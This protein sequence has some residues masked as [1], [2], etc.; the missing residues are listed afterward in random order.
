MSSLETLLGTLES[1]QNVRLTNAKEYYGEQHQAL[2]LI[3]VETELCHAVIA[4]QGAHVIEFTPKQQSPLLWV[5]PKVEYKSGKAIRGGV[6][7]C[8]PWFGENQLDKTQPSHGFVR[9]RDWQLTNASAQA[10]GEVELTLSFSSDETTYSLFPYH[11]K[12]V[13]KISLGRTLKLAL[14]VNNESDKTMPVSFALHSYHPVKDLAT[15]QVEGLH[16]TSFLDN[17][18]S[19]QAHIQQG[20]VEFNGEVDRIYLN[21]PTEQI[22]RTEPAIKLA[23]TS[24]K[25]AVVWNPGF[26]KADSMGDLGGEN[27]QEFVCVERGNA[28]SDSWYLAANE[29]KTAELEIS[30]CI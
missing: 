2:P 8:F 16:W 11:F 25:S 29:A 12:A 9:N 13:Y 5:S 24:C 28:F 20:P 1:V 27:Y 3:L 10:N 26:D 7:I 15:T 18:Q 14:T 17:T 23:S 4:I 21:V 30:H 22:I 19:Y 6:P